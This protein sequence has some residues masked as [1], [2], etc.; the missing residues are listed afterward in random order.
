MSLHIQEEYEAYFFFFIRRFMAFMT[1]L[2]ADLFIRRFAIVLFVVYPTR[3][4]CFD[5]D[6]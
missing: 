2:P 5:L 4:F 6:E 1:F 3:W